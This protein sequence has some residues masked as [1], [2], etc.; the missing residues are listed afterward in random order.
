M[1]VGGTILKVRKERKAKAEAAKKARMEA[2]T[3]HAAAGEES[4]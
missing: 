1:G 4:E 3:E 2:K